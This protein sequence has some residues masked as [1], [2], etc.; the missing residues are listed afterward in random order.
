MRRLAKLS[1]TRLVLLVAAL[2][3]I[4][5]AAFLGMRSWSSDSLDAATVLARSRDAEAEILAQATEGK[6]L[7]YQMKEYLRQGPAAP[8]VQEMRKDDF[9]VPES[10]LTEMWS[11]VGPSG[12]IARV[13]GRMTDEEG[14]MVQEVT[15]EG[16]EVVTRAP[17]S[18][19]EERWPLDWSVEDVAHGIAAEAR[20]L[21][22][23]IDT[24]RAKIVGYGN[25]GGK[26]TIILELRRWPEPEAEPTDA[27][28]HTGGYALPYTLDLASVKRV[29][30]TGIDADTFVPCRWWMVAVDSAGQEQILWDV[31]TVVYEVLDPAAVPAEVFGG[32]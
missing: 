32:R 2:G 12:R 3:V 7:H 29:E 5:V 18:G 21:R 10:T 17:A 16:N 11:Q 4:A 9:Y 27:D 22:E 1:L 25:I 6:V 15:T 24:D 23:S 26:K 8:L 28:V 19:A 13:Y 20:K 31:Q 30:R 14:R